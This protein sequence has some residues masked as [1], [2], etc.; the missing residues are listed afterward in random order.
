[1]LHTPFQFVDKDSP[2]SYAGTDHWQPNDNAMVS[3]Q[4][5]PKTHQ[6]RKIT[7]LS[8]NKDRMKQWEINCSSHTW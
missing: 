3:S 7:K 2:P 6:S 8:W 5:Q 4:N 1:V